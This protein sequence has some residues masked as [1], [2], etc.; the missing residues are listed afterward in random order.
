MHDIPPK[1]SLAFCLEF[2]HLLLKEVRLPKGVSESSG[3]V[4]RAQIRLCYIE[5]VYIKLA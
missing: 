4:G 2:V 1:D 5:K 3:I